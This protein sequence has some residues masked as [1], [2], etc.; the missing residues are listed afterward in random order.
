M[1]TDFWFILI[2]I[3]ILSLVMNWG[4]Q[5]SYYLWKKRKNKRTFAGQKTL[6]DYYTG[7]IGDGAIVPIINVLIYY[8]ILIIS[9]ERKIGVIGGI[10]GGRGLFLALVVGLAIDIL[11][12][13][14][15]G[16]LKLINWSMPRPFRWN[17]AGYWHMFSFPIQIAYLA[18]F[19]GTMVSNFS[20]VLANLSTRLATAAIVGLMLLFCFLYGK[21]NRWI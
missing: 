12:H 9:E 15:Q 16:K 17:F 20:I 8:V 13:Y 2:L 10:G 21:D 7:Y 11:A 5:L 3:A 19:F 1:N 18:L 6:L 4:V 14:L